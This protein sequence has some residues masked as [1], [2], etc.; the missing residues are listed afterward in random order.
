MI[1]HNYLC[2][3]SRFEFPCR[4]THSNFALTGN[5][6]SDL[7][8]SGGL[9]LSSLRICLRSNI[10]IRPFFSLKAVH[11]LEGR[12]MG[13]LPPLEMPASDTNAAT[14]VLPYT[15]AFSSKF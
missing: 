15:V 8:C 4:R 11:D 10:Q 9:V 12:I 7:L 1:F 6:T 14:E 3:I 2:I 13:Y 5:G